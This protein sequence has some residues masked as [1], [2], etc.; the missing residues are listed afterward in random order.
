[1][2]CLVQHSPC[3]LYFASI[4]YF[5]S[6]LYNS[7]SSVTV[8]VYYTADGSS[9]NFWYIIPR[10]YNIQSGKCGIIDI[11]FCI[12][13][14]LAFGVGSSLCCVAVCWF[15]RLFCVCLMLIYPL[16]V[17]AVRAASVASENYR[18]FVANSARHIVCILYKNTE[19]KTAVY[20]TAKL[21]RKHRYNIR[22]KI[23]K[24]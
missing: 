5:V 21:S 13:V 14:I 7:D 17:S 12:F 6:I 9:E 10:W 3:I 15:L 2:C 23:D 22:R 24:K 18:F 4:I 11:C 1:L 19:I 16:C 8:S 20:Y